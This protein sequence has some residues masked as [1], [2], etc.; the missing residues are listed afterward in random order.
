MLRAS[1]CLI[2]TTQDHRRRLG[3]DFGGPGKNFADQSFRMTFFRKKFPFQRRKFLMTLFSRRLYF[4]CFCL[5]LLS[6]YYTPVYCYIT[7]KTTISEKIP[8]PHLLYSVHTFIRIHY[9]PNTTSPNIGGTDAWAVPTSKFGAVLQFPLSLRPCPRPP[10]LKLEPT[11]HS[12][13]PRL[14]PLLYTSDLI[15]CTFQTD[16]P[17]SGNC[18]F[19]HFDFL[20]LYLSHSNTQYVKRQVILCS[21]TLVYHS[22]IERC[23]LWVENLKASNPYSDR[24][25]KW[26]QQPAVVIIMFCQLYSSHKVV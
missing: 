15:A 25:G 14:T 9:R 17:G 19:R 7:Y 6:Y 3:T 11:T 21:T 5:S 22:H 8:L 18:I 12:L 10:V 1:L 26:S 24:P 2:F 13:Q 23:D 16:M 20:Q 4:V